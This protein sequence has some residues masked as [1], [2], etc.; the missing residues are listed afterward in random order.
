[1]KALLIFLL[2][3]SSFATGGGGV[4]AGGGGGTTIIKDGKVRDI[5]L[6]SKKP[7]NID[8]G[9]RFGKV[10]DLPTFKNEVTIEDLETVE[11]KSKSNILLKLEQL[12]EVTL[13]DGTVYSSEE[14]QE[15]LTK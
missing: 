12:D 15:L 2:T 9:Q 7:I 1:M 11:Y 14:L 3:F 6:G 4:D 8:L 13:R 5:N 10:Y